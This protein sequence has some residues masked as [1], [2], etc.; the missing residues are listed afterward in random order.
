MA[1]D[2]VCSNC[3][4]SGEPETAVILV[5]DLTGHNLPMALGPKCVP[6]FAMMMLELYGVPESMEAVAEETETPEEEPEVEPKTLEEAQEL[7]RAEHRPQVVEEPETV[8]TST[9]RRSG[10]SPAASSAPAVG[11]GKRKTA[12]RSP[13]RHSTS[14]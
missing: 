1:Q 4:N 10:R 3:Q 12:T 9:R 11:N 8:P 13:A 7:L 6:A 5:S 2:M 14:G